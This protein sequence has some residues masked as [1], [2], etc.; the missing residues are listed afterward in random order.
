MEN[1]IRRTKPAIS[2]NCG[3][4]Q[5]TSGLLTANIKSLDLVA[6]EPGVRGSIY[7]GSNTVLTPQIFFHLA[8]ILVPICLY[9]LNCAKFGQLVLRT[10][11]KILATRYILRLKCTKF[12]FG[13]GSAQSAGPGSAPDS[14]GGAQ[15]SQTL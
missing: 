10:I 7:L 6:W 14:D 2:L 13:W 4:I 5:R 12:D 3:R 11:I 1:G 8:T 9:C 15:R